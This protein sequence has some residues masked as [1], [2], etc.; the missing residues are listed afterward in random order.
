MSLTSLLVPPFTQM[1]RNLAAWLDKAATHEQASGNEVDAL[2]SKRLAADMHPL[3]AQVRFA[4]F[5]AQEPAY[6]LRG[7]PVPEKLERVRRDGRNAG[8]QPGSLLDAQACLA[9]AIGFLSGLEPHALDE[10]AERTITLSLPDGTAFVM[11]GEQYARDWSLPQ[12]YF[13]TTTAYAILRNHGIGLGKADYV[14]HML[15]YLRPGP[16]PQG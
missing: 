13:H 2:L 12:F 6:R 11:T 15:A 4:S 10:G 3:S 9:D 8:Q 16:T 14:S 1:L 7:Q 5:Q